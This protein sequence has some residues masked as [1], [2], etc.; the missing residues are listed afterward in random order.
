MT[1]TC[2][3][4]SI[5]GAL[6]LPLDTYLRLLGGKKIPAELSVTTVNHKP[7]ALSTWTNPTEMLPKLERICV[8]T[9]YSQMASCKAHS[10]QKEPILTDAK[11][12]LSN[13]LHG[14]RAWSWS[15]TPHLFHVGHVTA[16]SLWTSSGWTVHSAYLNVWISRRDWRWS[17]REQKLAEEWSACLLS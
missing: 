4:I 16:D 3:I 15:Y 1:F 14:T 13:K 11:P 8:Y 2:F 9:Y 7:V 10:K 12:S 6:H 5:T 17:V